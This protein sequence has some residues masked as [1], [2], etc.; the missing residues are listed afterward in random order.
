MS[1][2]RPLT[3][4]ES[5]AR[6]R[7]RVLA[8][9]EKVF[10]KQG[11]NAASISGIARAAG[12]TTGA[13]YSNF[14][15]K[16]SLGLAVMERRMASVALTL[17]S[18]LA[19]AEPTVAARLAAV[20]SL[21]SGFFG[22]EGWAMF[23]AEFVIAARHKPALRAELGQ[24]LGTAREMTALLLSQQGDEV[25]VELPVDAHRLATGVVA[26]AVGLSVLRLADPDAAKG[27]FQETAALLLGQLQPR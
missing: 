1:I 2:R 22:D 25:G 20:E 23:T 6:T 11:Y 24:R 17:Q 27:A 18:V 26:L 3:R 13:V 19:T 14:E 8:A 7:D 16:E 9:A 15:S 21:W 5:Q 10:L 12:F 4:Q